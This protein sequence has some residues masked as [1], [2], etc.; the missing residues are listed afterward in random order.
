MS[1][2]YSHNHIKLNPLFTYDR[3][4]TVLSTQDVHGYLPG[5]LH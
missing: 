1:S 4:K 3:L 5:C 2:T